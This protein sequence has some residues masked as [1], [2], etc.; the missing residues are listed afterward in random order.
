MGATEAQASPA[1]GI[2]PLLMGLGACAWS[3]LWERNCSEASDANL[4]E[5]LRGKLWNVL[6]GRPHPHWGKCGRE[7]SWVRLVFGCVHCCT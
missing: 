3:P 7:E 6:L 4:G 5:G 2:G 1:P